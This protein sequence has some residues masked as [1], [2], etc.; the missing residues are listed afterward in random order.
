MRASILL[1]ALVAVSTLAAGA[2]WACSCVRYDSAAQQLAEAYVMFVGR[3]TSFSNHAM[4][5]DYPHAMH[6]ARFEVRRTIKG[7]AL[8]VRAVMHAVDG[9]MCGVRFTPDRDYTILARVQ[10]GVLTTSACSAPQFPLSDYERA[11]RAE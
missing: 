11:A 4:G 8:P 9:A 10:D 3:M 1:A 5:D 2:A 7:E 6:M